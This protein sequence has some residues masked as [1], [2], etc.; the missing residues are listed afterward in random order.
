MPIIYG[1]RIRLRAAE[2]TDI[3]LFLK[4]FNDPEVTENLET[5]FPI[6]SM[7][8]EKW[9]EKMQD[10]NPAQH[11]LVIEMK[12]DEAGHTGWAAVGDVAFHN[13]DWIDRSAEVGICIGEKTCWN[14]GLG[15]ET[16]Q[17]MLDFGFGSLN[18]HRIYLRVYA[19]NKRGIRAYEKTGYTHEGIMRQAHYQA[20]AYVDVHLMSVLKHEWQLKQQNKN[21]EVI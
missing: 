3:P 2:K 11:P 4:W 21:D 15:T 16:M 12:T 9:L 14:Q 7:G 19:K 1:K 10:Q 18:L 6:S 5:I 17:L 20:G 13:I 8:E